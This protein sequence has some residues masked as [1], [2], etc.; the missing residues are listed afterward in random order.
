MIQRRFRFSDAIV[1]SL[2]S[3]WAPC[4]IMATDQAPALPDLI[5]DRL[6]ELAYAPSP[7]RESL[8][9]P[10]ALFVFYRKRNY[11]PGWTRDGLLLARAEDLIRALAEADLEGLDRADYH[12]GPIQRLAGDIISKNKKRKAVSPMDMAD[13]DLY[14]SDAFIIYAAHLLRGKVDQETIEPAWGLWP[15]ELTLASF[16]EDS[17]FA[18]GVRDALRGLL[19]RHAHYGRLRRAFLESRAGENDWPRIKDGPPFGCG[20]RGRRVENLR[21]RLEASGDCPEASSGARDVFDDSLER[22]L[23]LFQ[24]RHGLHPTGVLDGSTM[25]L[26][27]L[28]REEWTRRLLVNLERWRWLPRDLGPLYLLVNVADFRLGV[29]ERERPVLTMK[30]VAG[31]RDWPTPVFASR[32]YQVILNPFWVIPAEVVLKE[33]KNYMLADPNYLTSNKMKLYRGWGDEIHELDPK[34]VDWKNL[35]AENLNFH[36]RQAPGPLN[37]LGAVKFAMMNKYEIYLHDTPYQE[38]FGKAFRA[39]SHGCIRV[40]KPIDLAVRILKGR[41]GWTAE[42]LREAIALGAETKIDLAKAVEVY[43]LYGTAWANEDRTVEFRLDAYQLDARLYEALR[44]PAPWT[45]EGARQALK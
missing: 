18:E 42:S 10:E 16:L 15:S 40:E 34:A 44:W 8:G 24:E 11:E 21:R 43:F 30:I 27:N 23:R 9:A 19:P 39:Y 5:R 2:L 37:V 17:L 29:F 41:N 3:L 28:P 20:D 45:S 4:L 6:T 12:Y 1:I 31:N 35:D 22:G 26:L 32:I 7:D 36:I 14:C 13:L 25:T 33:T 38:D